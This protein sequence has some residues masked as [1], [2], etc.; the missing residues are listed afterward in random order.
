[1][2]N[3]ER[4]WLLIAKEVALKEKKKDKG[5]LGGLLNLGNPYA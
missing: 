1:L 2:K 3:N 4:G 5:F